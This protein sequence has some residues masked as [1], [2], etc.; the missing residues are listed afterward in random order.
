M[1]KF[2]T[3]KR[4]HVRQCNNLKIFDKRDSSNEQRKI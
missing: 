2:L 1:K 3:K 4:H